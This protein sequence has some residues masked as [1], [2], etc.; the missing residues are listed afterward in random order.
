LAAKSL[1]AYYRSKHSILDGE[2][3]AKF[4]ICGNVCDRICTFD[5][6]KVKVKS[7]KTVSAKLRQ[8][9]QPQLQLCTAKKAKKLQNS[10]FWAKFLTIF[11]FC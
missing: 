8:I 2:I 1:K 4:E 7:V 5:K 3:M 10:E 9:S 6:R 11:A